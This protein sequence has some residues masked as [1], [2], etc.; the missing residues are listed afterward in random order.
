MA[1][2]ECSLSGDFK[3]ILDILHSGILNGSMSA[4]YEEGSD[5]ICDNV[6]TSVRV[7]ERYSMLGGNRLSLNIVLTGS[8][9]KI[10]LSAI[11][12]GGSQAVFFKINT[13]GEESF[14]DCV[15]DI[16]ERYQRRNY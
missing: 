16:V 12:S 2:Y 14:L 10:Y 1:K 6:R 15:R 11:T 8:N 3:D 5:F 9:D 13:F 4:S 7:Y